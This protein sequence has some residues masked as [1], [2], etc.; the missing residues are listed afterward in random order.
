MTTNDYYTLFTLALVTLALLV[1]PPAVKFL[2]LV[3]E[4]EREFE[5]AK[6]RIAA[7]QLARP[8][9]PA[10]ISGEPDPEEQT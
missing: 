2:R 6:R 5:A 8:N 4:G 7:R 1:V 9:L 3:K 10:V